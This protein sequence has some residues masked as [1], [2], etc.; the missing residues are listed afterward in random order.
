MTNH[1]IGVIGCGYWG[2][3]LIRNFVEIQNADV[4]GV[5]DLREDRLKFIKERYNTI[6]TTTD[7]H[8]LFEM[9]VDAVVIATPPSTH[10]PLSRECLDNNLHVMVE[11]PI[12][13]NSKDAETLVDMAAERNRILMVGHTFEYNPAVRAL[14]N[15]IKSGE[16]GDIY[17]ID[18]VRVNL[19]LFQKDLNVIWDLAPHDVSILRFLL[20]SDPV[21]V[22]ACGSASILPDIHDVAYIYMEFPNNIAAHLHVSWL[23]PCKVRRITVVGSQKMLVYDDIEPLEK[24]RIYDKGVEKPA[25]THTFSDF[26]LS[27]R[28]GDVV[29]PHI[30]FTEPLRVECAHFLESIENG[31]PPLSSGVDGLEVVKTLELA[32]QSLAPTKQKKEEAYGYSP[33]YNR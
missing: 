3:N 20:D 1:R 19:G 22:S 25:Y 5:A 13:L 11:K 15:I 24:I 12:T 16:L 23:D 31:T 18:A 2:P 9:G 28:H 6:T 4:V 17:Y 29:I 32:E 7:Y 27:Y 8:D 14:K 21:G 10:Y 33:V 30:K 26:Q